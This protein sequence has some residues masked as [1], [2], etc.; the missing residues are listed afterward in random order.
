MRQN[1]GTSACLVAF[2][3]GCATV[4]EGKYD[5]ADGWRRGWIEKIG[6]AAAFGNLRPDDCRRGATAETLA[7]HQY[8]DVGYIVGRR[9]RGRVVQMPIDSRLKIGDSVYFNITNCNALPA[10]HG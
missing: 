8:A 10:S 6:E 9:P 4:Y 5:T 1:I 7:A 2:L 3:C